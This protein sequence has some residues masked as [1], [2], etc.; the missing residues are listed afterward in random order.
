V[1]T[2]GG[3]SQALPHALHP[4]T[5][6]PGEVRHVVVG[7]RDHSTLPRQGGELLL[8]YGT[9]SGSGAMCQW[10]WR[11]PDWPPRLMRY[12][13][14]QERLGHPDRATSAREHARQ[15]RKLHEQALRELHGWAGPAPAGED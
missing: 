5:E 1:A 3:A 8:R 14:L 2:L 4:S 11:F 9:P 12:A 15:A 6:A 13:V 7:Q 10:T